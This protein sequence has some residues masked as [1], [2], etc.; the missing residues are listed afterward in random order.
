[1][2]EIHD[3]ERQVV[4]DVGRGKILVELETVEDHWPVGDD[5]DVAQVQVAMA[6][7]N[8]ALAGAPIEEGCV[9]DQRIAELAV[10]RGRS[11]RCEETA[12]DEGSGIDVQHARHALSSTGVAGHLRLLVQRN[13]GGREI[14]H[15]RRRERTGG[16]QPVEEAALVEGV[17]AH[18]RIDKHPAFVKDEAASR[19]PDDA[20]NALVDEAIRVC[21]PVEAILA[22][23]EHQPPLG[24]REVEIGEPH[25]PLQLEHDLAPDH[26][27][28]NMGRDELG[29]R[30]RLTHQ[31]SEN[32]G[33]VTPSLQNMVDAHPVA[34]PK[35]RPAP[36]CIAE[37]FA[38]L[39]DEDQAEVTACTT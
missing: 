39:Y 10:E 33:G 27:V 6:A 8:L 29:T 11:L 28:R 23:A 13:D 14:I 16:R 1:V 5:A 20:A 15:Q 17:H 31:E 21:A 12:V 26:H 22:L 25:R 37:M 4:E 32:T 2:P 30:T 36:T 34:S 38:A 18:H 3:E 7:A 24:R 9:A 35:P 19:R